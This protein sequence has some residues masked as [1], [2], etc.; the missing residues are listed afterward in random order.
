MKKR[1]FSFAILLVGA[2]AAAAPVTITNGRIT[3]AYDDG[4]V[5]LTAPGS[6]KPAATVTTGLKTATLKASVLSHPARK[7]Q[8]LSLRGP[9]GSIAFKIEDNSPRFTVTYNRNASPV[10]VKWNAAAV[11]VPDVFAE[12]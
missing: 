2:A 10:T 11:V 9:D 6:D 5:R 7:F 4:V 1:F 12:D 3:L 8:L